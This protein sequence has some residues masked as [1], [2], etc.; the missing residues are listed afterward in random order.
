MINPW[1]SL[2]AVAATILLIVVLYALVRWRRAPAAFRAIMATLAASMFSGFLLGL[3]A[4]HV[5]EVASP[6][7]SASPSAE[8]RA[9]PASTP[10]P[11]PSVHKQA[12]YV[13]TDKTV[14]EYSLSGE[15][16][17]PI[18]TIGGNHTGLGYGGALA[19]DSTG[20]MYVLN[21]S[22]HTIMRYAAGTDG[23]TAPT[24]IIAGPATRLEEPY[25][26]F[27]RGDTSIWVA[28]DQRGAGYVLEFASSADGNAPPLAGF[29]VGEPYFD[30]GYGMAIDPFGR[31]WLPNREK[32]RVIGILAR[33]AAS[34]VKRLEGPVTGLDGPDGLAFD[35]VGRL[36]VANSI[37]NSITVYPP[38]SAGAARPTQTI[39]GPATE[40]Q[41]PRRIA[42]D[43]SRQIYASAGNVILRFAPGTN[44]DL[45]PAGRIVLSSERGRTIDDFAFGVMT[46]PVH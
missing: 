2:L 11:A 46:R 16:A 45:P 8:A 34:A 40:L 28:D 3:L 12:L 38:N 1:M 32:N 20:A 31:I 43:A 14:T 19:V 42:V 10:H 4:L 15:I 41:T 9:L 24:T 5:V 22:A 17:T 39:F 7:P 30:L 29:S 44:G 23:D 35:V 37:G 36:Y 33:G 27:A 18:L 25:A 6:K 21:R 13:L 26:I